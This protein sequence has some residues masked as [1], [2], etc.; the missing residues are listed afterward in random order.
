MK[1]YCLEK[2]N[3][4]LTEWDTLMLKKIFISPKLA[5]NWTFLYFIWQPY[6]ITTYKHTHLESSYKHFF[7]S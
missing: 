2:N 5:F 4:K 1:I 3:Y 6:Y 7:A